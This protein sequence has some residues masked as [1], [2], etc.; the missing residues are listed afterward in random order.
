MHKYYFYCN[1]VDDFL[2]IS[3][4]LRNELVEFQKAEPC[5]ASKETLEYRV[6]IVIS[7]QYQV[8]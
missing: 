8:Y 6:M 4:N 1:H 5:R 7:R 2:G 3:K